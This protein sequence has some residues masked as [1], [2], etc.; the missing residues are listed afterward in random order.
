MK[1]LRSVAGYLLKTLLLLILATGIFLAWQSIR[2]FRPQTAEVIPVDGVAGVA[3]DTLT[4]ATYNIGYCGLGAEMDFFYEGGTMVRPEKETYD[5]YLGGVIGRIASLPDPDIIFL[6]EV[7]TLAKRSWYSNQ[8]RLLSNRFEK[9]HAFFA[10]NYRAWVPMP[11]LKPMG[12]VHAGL[13]LMSK[14]NPAGVQRHAFSEGYK[15]PMSLFMLKRCFM[16]ARYQTSDGKQLVLVNTHNSAF[17]DAAEIREKELGELKAFLME[18]YAKGNYVIAG[19]DW[20][21]NP[22]AFDTAAVKASYRVKTITPPIPADFT[23]EGWHYAW[24]PQHPT[25]RDVDIPYHDGRTFTTL[26]DFFLL[27]PNVSLLGANAIQTGFAESDHQPV[28][29]KVA[30]KK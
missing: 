4:I 22:P 23:P 21:Q 7:D 28:V 16:E 29:V 8:Y 20:N 3:G 2:E 11:L 9:Y 19:G 12:K 5:K 27:S 30:L 26:I 15:W 18:E 24:D 1:F 6:Q 25:N 13:M 17:S 10:L 14:T